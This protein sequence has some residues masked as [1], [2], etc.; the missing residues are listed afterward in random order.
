MKGKPR[1]RKPH[2]RGAGRGG[3][4]VRYGDRD[5]ADCESAALLYGLAP[6]GPGPRKIAPVPERA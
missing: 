3:T 1:A 5:K 6:R 4:P 2:S